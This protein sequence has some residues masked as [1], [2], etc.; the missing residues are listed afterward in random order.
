MIVIRTSGEKVE[1]KVS[2]V[3]RLHRLITIDILEYNSRFVF[4]D[5]AGSISLVE[6]GRQPIDKAWPATTHVSRS[7]Y[8]AMAGWAG[9]ILNDRR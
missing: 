9:S 4:S 7:I 3:D 8:R 5:M 6:N 1:L 2:A